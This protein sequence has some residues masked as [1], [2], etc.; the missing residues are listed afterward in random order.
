MENNEKKIILSEKGKELANVGAFR[1]RFIGIRQNGELLKYSTIQSG[2]VHPF[3]C[4]IVWFF[5]S[6]FFLVP[7]V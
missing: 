1:Y 3:S 7:I 6:F 2:N 5:G 4:S